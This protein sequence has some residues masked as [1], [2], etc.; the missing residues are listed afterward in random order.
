MISLRDQRN[1][2]QFLFDEEIKSTPRLLRRLN[3]PIALDTTNALRDIYT[4]HNL[5]GDIED[6]L[7]WYSGQVLSTKQNENKMK[8]K[9]SNYLIVWDKDGKRIPVVYDFQREMLSMSMPATLHI[10][11][12][13]KTN[14]A[15]RG[16]SAVILVE[17][18]GDS[19]TRQTNENNNDN[20]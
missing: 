4:A 13:P 12:R 18:R 3:A 1:E 10:K 7:S 14:P 2:C 8:T 19:N 9:R 11:E 6:L 16:K 15:K 17:D 5:W 20:K